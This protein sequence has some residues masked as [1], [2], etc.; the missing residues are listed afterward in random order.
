MNE[1]ILSH[2]PLL[3]SDKPLASQKPSLP[4]PSLPDLANV[5]L[6]LATTR[7]RPQR[8][9]LAAFSLDLCLLSRCSRSLPLY[10]PCSSSLVTSRFRACV[11]CL[12][13]VSSPPLLLPLALSP[14]LERLDYFADPI[15]V[16]LA[17]ASSS[18][19]WAWLKTRRRLSLS[20][21]SVPLLGFRF[22]F[23]FRARGF[24]TGLK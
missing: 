19:R 17:F 15:R 5:L 16:L 23:L 18:L 7:R 8:R 22:P 4:E 20:T 10:S 3:F 14:F 6:S 1:H 11:S 21:A 2:V 24:G 13:K 12:S 9:S